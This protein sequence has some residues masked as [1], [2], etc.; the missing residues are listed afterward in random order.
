MSLIVVWAHHA[1]RVSQMV[2]GSV[3]VAL[4]ERATHPVAVVPVSAHP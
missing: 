4:V 1:N 3:S 2:F